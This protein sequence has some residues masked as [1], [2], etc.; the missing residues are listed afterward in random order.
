MA[1]DRVELERDKGE[2]FMMECAHC[3]VRKEIHVND[4]NA[5]PNKIVTGVGVAVGVAAAV[6]LWNIGFIAWISGGLPVIIYGAQRKSASTF[7]SYYLT[8][9]N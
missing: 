9:R 2:T 7:N 4:V 3:Y 8:R 6:A 1:T 5:V